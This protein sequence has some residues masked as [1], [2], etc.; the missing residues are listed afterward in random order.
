MVTD[1]HEACRAAAEYAIM[2]YHVVL[3]PCGCTCSPTG[4]RRRVGA[5][6][7]V[8]ETLDDIASGCVLEIGRLLSVD[9]LLDHGLHE[10]LSI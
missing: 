3:P 7:V 5:F 10:W 6:D 8:V 9:L 4:C 2:V 1:L